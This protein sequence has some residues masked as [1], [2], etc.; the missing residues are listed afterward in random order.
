MT[1][2]STSCVTGIYGKAGKQLSD[3][4]ISSF[5]EEKTW[6]PRPS[7]PTACPCRFQH[8]QTKTLFDRGTLVFL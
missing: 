8:G 6:V 3:G 1:G 7:S 4:T 5:I 2:T